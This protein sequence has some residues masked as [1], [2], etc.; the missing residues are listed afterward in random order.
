MKFRRHILGLNLNTLSIFINIKIL[1]AIRVVLGGT[2]NGH[3]T[4][5][6]STNTPLSIRRLL[7]P[8]NHR[9]IKGHRSLR[10]S[11]S[12][13]STNSQFLFLDRQAT[14]LKIHA[15]R[16]SHVLQIK[17]SVNQSDLHIRIMEIAAQQTITYYILY[18]IKLRKFMLCCCQEINFFSNLFYS[19]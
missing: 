4:T 6:E 8:A 19:R 5:S 10:S 3:L 14:R 15:Q 1:H 16:Q 9:T 7:I 2:R 18:Q 12:A 13:I 11:Y 17:H